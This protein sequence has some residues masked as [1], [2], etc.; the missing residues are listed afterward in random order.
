MCDLHSIRVEMDYVRS[1]AN[2]ADAPSRMCQKGMSK[3]GYGLGLSLLDRR[4]GA[5]SGTTDS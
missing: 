2:P 5:N 3:N 4:V 1:A